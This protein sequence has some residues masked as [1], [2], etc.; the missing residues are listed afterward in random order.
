MTFD[1]LHYYLEEDETI[2][3]EERNNR[4]DEFLQNRI[5]KQKLI[6]EAISEITYLLRITE[7]CIYVIESVQC[8]LENKTV[9]EYST[10][11]ETIDYL[12]DSRKK[13]NRFIKKLDNTGEN[14]KRKRRKK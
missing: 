8:Q 9:P 1:R 14:T 10:I 2:S 6:N 12:I 11:S 7:I 5:P 3:E 13:L 4:F